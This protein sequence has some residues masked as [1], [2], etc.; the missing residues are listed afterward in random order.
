MTSTAYSAPTSSNPYLVGA[1]ATR[2]TL[3]NHRLSAKTSNTM[4]LLTL[5]LLT[6]QNL[7]SASLSGFKK[8]NCPP[9]KKIEQTLRSEDTVRIAENRLCSNALSVHLAE[10]AIRR[11]SSSARSASPVYDTTKAELASSCATPVLKSIPP[12]SATDLDGLLH[13]FPHL[14]SNTSC[15]F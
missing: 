14:Q 4:R 6:T 11:T 1:T 8:L 10:Y 13:C 15:V 7:A 2:T 3:H 9:S 5:P 12:H